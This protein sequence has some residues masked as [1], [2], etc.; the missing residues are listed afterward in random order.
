MQELLV[1]HGHQDVV[2]QCRIGKKEEGKGREKRGGGYGE[3]RKG[4]IR[5]RKRG[6]K[7]GPTSWPWLPHR[8]RQTHVC[9]L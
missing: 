5:E 3:R 9:T 7:E 2:A 8:E 4:M 6:K 1:A